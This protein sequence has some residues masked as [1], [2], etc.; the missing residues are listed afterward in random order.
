MPSTA[1]TTRIAMSATLSAGQ[2][3]T[4]EVGVARRVEEVDLVRVAVAGLPFERGDAERQRHAPFH[5]LRVGAGHRGAVLDATDACRDAGSMQQCL[6]QC[7]LAGAT[8]ADQD[9]VTDAIGWD[10]F[11][12]LDPQ[13][14]M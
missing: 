8:V 5:F 2:L 3:L 9:D 13:C 12:R 10:D 1:L 11:Q 4:D 7:G 6:D 14:S